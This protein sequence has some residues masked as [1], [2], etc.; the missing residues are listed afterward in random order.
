[1]T[2]PSCPRLFEVE[3]M[4]DGRLTG[5]ERATFERHVTGCAACSREVQT[6]EALAEPLRAEPEDGAIVDEFHVRRERTRLLAAFEQALVSSKRSPN[7]RRHWLWVASVATIAAGLLIL[8]HERPAAQPGHWPRAVVRADSRAVWSER[9]EGDRERIVL[10]RGTLWIQVDHSSGEGRLVIALP[11][12]ELEDIGTIFT[13][14]VED[15]HTGRVAVKKGHVVLR[16][17]DRPPVAI[18]PGDTWVPEAVS[19]FASAAPTAEPAPN[20]LH[21]PSVGSA[22]ALPS[23]APAPTLVA[24]DPLV[25][26]RAAMA[27]LDVGDNRQ[28]ATAFASFLEKHPRAPRAEDAAYLR[29]IALQKSGDSDATKEAAS[30]YLRRYPKGFRHS[31]VERLSP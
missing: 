2:A 6:L 12:G 28:A 18:G 14:S 10:E 15:G 30:D 20:G 31:E 17:H 3:A 27:A 22:S 9:T 16:M 11:D 29:V 8:R 23:P 19:A 24:P 4:R 26:F 1:M 7:A 25:D 21:A 5:A 13:V